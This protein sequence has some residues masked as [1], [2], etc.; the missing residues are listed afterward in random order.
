MKNKPRQYYL[1]K[2]RRK[3]NSV[4]YFGI[5]QADWTNSNHTINIQ[6]SNHPSAV[7]YIIILTSWDSWWW[8]NARPAVHPGVASRRGSR[9]ACPWTAAR[10]SASGILIDQSALDNP[11]CECRGVL[12]CCDICGK[13][14]CISSYV[15]RSYLWFT[16]LLV[17]IV[18]FGTKS[19]R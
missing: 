6:H 16:S 11:A 18:N 3:I 12:R 10:L 1:L 17:S 15:Q 13:I 14:I 4:V 7:N 9:P 2:L 8:V 5:F 19:W